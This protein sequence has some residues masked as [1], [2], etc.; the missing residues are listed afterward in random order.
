MEYRYST[1]NRKNLV[2]CSC[3]RVSFMKSRGG[4]YDGIK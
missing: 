3:L 2:N 4:I 1:N